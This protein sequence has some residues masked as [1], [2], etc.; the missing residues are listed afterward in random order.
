MDQEMQDI[1]WLAKESAAE[2]Q[3]FGDMFRLRRQE[4]R[5]FLDNVVKLQLKPRM[6]AIGAEGLRLGHIRIEDREHVAHLP[7]RVTGKL[8]QSANSDHEWSIGWRHLQSSRYEGTCCLAAL[9]PQFGLSGTVRK[10]RRSGNAKPEGLPAVWR[11]SSRCMKRLTLAGRR[12]A[13]A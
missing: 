4:T 3:D 11:V 9:I 5:G 6:F 1:F 8:F 12:S 2:L 10:T 7:V 13:C